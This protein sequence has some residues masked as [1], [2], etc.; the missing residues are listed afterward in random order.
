MHGQSGAEFEQGLAVA[1][2]ECVEDVP[3]GRRRQRVEQVRHSVTIGKCEL[4]CQRPPLSDVAD[5]SRSNRDDGRPVL[6]SIHLID[7]FR[8]E[9]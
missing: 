2:G 5:S 6:D 9:Q 4:A 7:D 3:A 1:F 8:I